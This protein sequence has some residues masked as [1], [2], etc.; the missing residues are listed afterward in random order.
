M[1]AHY[2]KVLPPEQAKKI[3]A[4]MTQ[5]AMEAFDREPR[6]PVKSRQKAEDAQKAPNP[7]P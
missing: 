4:E 3:L 2:G 6:K 5:A 1:N 7:T